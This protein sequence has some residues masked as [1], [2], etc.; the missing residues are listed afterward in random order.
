MQQD[1]RTSELLDSSL[2]EQ[3]RKKGGADLVK[4][5]PRFLRGRMARQERVI[6]SSDSA[7][8]WV[9]RRAALRRPAIPTATTASPISLETNW[10]LCK[11]K[12]KELMRRS[13]R[14]HRG[15]AANIDAPM[16]REIH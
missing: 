11:A 10:R 4:L 2:P 1:Q 7:A 12:L 13:P 9:A 5:V 16:E 14:Q 8:S 3:G 6:H 15:L